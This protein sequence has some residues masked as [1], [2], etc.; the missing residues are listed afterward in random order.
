MAYKRIDR[1]ARP[2]PRTLGAVLSS[3]HRICRISMLAI[4]PALCI[5]ACKKTEDRLDHSQEKPP[6]GLAGSYRLTPS[7]NE[8]T[9]VIQSAGETEYRIKRPGETAVRHGLS[10][11]NRFRLV[12]FLDGDA[13]PTGIFLLQDRAARWPGRWRGEMRF[14]E[15]TLPTTA[16]RADR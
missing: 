8:E 13:E 4:L 1:G 2:S 16:E 5:T 12:V 15:T 10:Y 3:L 7:Y 6:A 14:L 11:Q 9:L